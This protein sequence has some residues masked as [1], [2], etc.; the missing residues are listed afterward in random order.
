MND[1]PLIALRD[2]C[3]EF[4]VGDETVHALDHV[5]LDIHA[6]DYISVMGPSGSGKSTLLNMLGLLDQTN[7]GSYRFAGRELT[8]LP[9][10]QRAQVRRDNIGF[11]FQSFHLIPR[12]TAAEN[13]ELPLVLTGMPASE[14]K[15]K[16][17]QALA[18]LGLAD[19][20]DHRPAQLS[21]GQQQRVAIAR[22]TIMHAPLLLAD[23]PTGNLDSHSS[24]EVIRILEDLN[25]LGITLVVVTHDT[26]IGKRARR[27]IRMV[28]GR[29]VG[30]DA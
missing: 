19:R 23:E 6:G 18:G 26:E 20:A 2:I 3:R 13:V 15:I 4:Q 22:A 8:T 10:E 30:D 29:V 24:T 17:R 27:R 9:E 11:I 21:G 12:L 14:R 1:E 28:D 16:V 25:T 7:A 5:S